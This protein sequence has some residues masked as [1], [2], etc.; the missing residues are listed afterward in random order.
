MRLRIV[1]GEPTRF[2]A[3]NG[4]S[5]AGSVSLRVQCCTSVMWPLLS[6][7]QSRSPCAKPSMSAPG[8][9]VA[10]TP[11][12]FA[13]SDD[14]RTAVEFAVE[15]LA[16][17]RHTALFVLAVLAIVPLAALLSHATESVAAK[18]GDAFTLVTDAAT[19]ES[20]AVEAVA[21]G[22]VLSAAVRLNGLAPSLL[23]GAF[24]AHRVQ[25]ARGGAERVLVRVQLDELAP[26]RLLARDIGLQAAYQRTD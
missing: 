2:E 11:A 25:H 23:D 24:G 5:C 6:E 4:P 14:K 1:A 21:P 26:L 15:H 16:P 18:T 20:V 12:A 3:M 17:D 7:Y 19:F 8:F 13:L 9:S 10:A 22:S